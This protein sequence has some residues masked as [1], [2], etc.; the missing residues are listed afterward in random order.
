LAAENEVFS[1]RSKKEGFWNGQSY[2]HETRFGRIPF[3]ALKFIQSTAS[4]PFSQVELII[5]NL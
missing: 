2:E 1:V 4:Q 5:V 3:S